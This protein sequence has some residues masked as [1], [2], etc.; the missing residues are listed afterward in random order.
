MSSLHIN[1]PVDHSVISIPA[2]IQIIIDRIAGKVMHLHLSVILST[3]VWGRE[4][5]SIE[6]WVWY[7]VE[8]LDRGCLARGCLQSRVSAQAGYQPR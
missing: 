1:G 7:I 3:T 5:V 2:Q 4:E 6:Q 8:G